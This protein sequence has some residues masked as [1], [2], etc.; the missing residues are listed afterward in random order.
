MKIVFVVGGLLRPDGMSQVL[1]DIINYLA[2]NTHFNIYMIL[3][4]KAG[5]PWFYE[6]SPKV[7]FINFN[8]NFDDLDNMPLPKKL[9]QF[10]KKQKK[11]KKLFA[12]YLM[13]IRP[14]ITVS[15]LRREINFINEIND[16]SKKIAKIHFNKSNYREA[17]IKYFP[18]FI[19]LLITKKWQADLVKHIRKL[20]RFIVL[21]EEDKKAWVELKNIMVIPNALK[22][23][24]TESSKCI[25]KKVIAVG[26]Y[27]PEKGF[28]R[29]I[30]AWAIVNNK[31]NDWKLDIYGSGNRFAYQK[32]AAD[33]GL[34]NSISCN[35]ATK[36][37][38][39]K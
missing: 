8:L 17:N 21:T 14:D 22:F 25:N 38:Y 31:H 12:N 37:I 6:I 32:L 29:L 19:N 27:S 7:K 11:Y 4:E 36:N 20:D 3:T 28:D 23:I 2:E 34:T 35:E 5:E 15:E 33:K 13:E 16:G 24:P 26:R 10:W 39:D 18:H 30:D 9:I 1:S